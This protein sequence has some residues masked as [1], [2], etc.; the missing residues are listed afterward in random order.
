[1][2]KA[3]FASM[4]SY[5]LVACLA[6]VVPAAAHF[7]RYRRKV[8]VA[9]L[10][11]FA[12]GGALYPFGLLRRHFVPLVVERFKSAE[13]QLLEMREGLT[14]TVMYLRTSFR[15]SRSITD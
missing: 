15:G 13:P 6:M 11:L 9:A 14:E 1:M 12:L 5:G 7:N 2:E 8:L 3:L 10:A 4:L